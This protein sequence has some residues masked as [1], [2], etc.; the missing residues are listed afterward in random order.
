SLSVSSEV[1]ISTSWLNGFGTLSSA[2]AGDDSSRAPA[3]AAQ[4]AGRAMM[5]FEVRASR[6]MVF[7]LCAPTRARR[8]IL[9]CVR[10]VASGAGGV[11]GL[12]RQRLGLG[13]Q[14]GVGGRAVRTYGTA[15]HGR[16]KA[17]ACPLWDEA[18]LRG[19]APR[20]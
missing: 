7:L 5:N 8:K 19:T 11:L 4:T 20:R 9:P 1:L 13:R 17:V 12:R 14:A 18:Q 6:V 2:P 10:S 3:T 16:A 15:G